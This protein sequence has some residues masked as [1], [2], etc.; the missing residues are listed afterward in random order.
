MRRG[1]RLEE[2]YFPALPIHLL[3]T[4]RS[5]TY[6]GILF[7]FLC[8]HNSFFRFPSFLPP[9]HLCY[10]CHHHHFH[11]HHYYCYYCYF[12]IPLNG[13]RPPAMAG[14]LLVFTAH[15]L[16]HLF[17]YFLLYTPCSFCV[18]PLGWR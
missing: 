11:Y 12:T 14:S 1:K 3:L 17:F 13:Q 9:L 7:F 4:T 2:I 8:L 15:R 10:N 5:D 18:N 16:W 6:T